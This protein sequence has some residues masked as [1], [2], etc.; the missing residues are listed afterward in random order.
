MDTYQ[1]HFYYF[2]SLSG[3][4]SDDDQRHK[5]RIFSSN[6]SSAGKSWAAEGGKQSN[7]F[8][9]Q[10]LWRNQGLRLRL[11]GRNPSVSSQKKLIRTK[12]SKLKQCG[13]WERERLADLLDKVWKILACLLFPWQTVYL[14]SCGPTPPRY[15]ES[16]ASFQNQ[17]FSDQ[18]QFQSPRCFLIRWRIQD[19]SSAH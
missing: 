17:G 12:P 9:L 1:L 4:R 6:I 7:I 16:P 14:I 3:L 2:I 13:V 15:L 5:L 8:S 10:Q 19:S 18:F 11:P